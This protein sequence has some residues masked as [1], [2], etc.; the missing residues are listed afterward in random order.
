[1]QAPLRD[2]HLVRTPENVTFEFELAGVGSRGLAWV[3]DLAAMGALILVGSY[4]LAA[5]QPVLGGFAV[6][7]QVLA[8][9]LVIWW[10][11]ALC[12]W[13]LGGQTLG[14][15]AVGIRTLQT[16]GVRITFLQAVVRNLVRIVD[17]I[18]AFYLI[19]AAAALLDRR[20]RRLGDMAAGTVVVRERAAPM[21]SAVV[22][23]TER[24]NTF[25]RDPSII[26]A[27]RRITAPERDAMLALGLRRDALPLP[28][29]RRL[30]ARMA[31]HLSRRLDVRRPPHFSEEK[32]VLNLTA[33]LLTR[34]AGA[35]GQPKG[36]RT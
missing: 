23:S 20:G 6:A 27:A 1:M 5:A 29:R 28:L 30:F 7:A 14:K 9:S 26:Q 34:S 12:E 32:L 3:V 19:G 11:A 36:G 13:W 21:P 8:V 16:S 15:R 4:V 35:P 25:V 22:P 24:H 31:D 33:V 2:R 10:Y 18:P 17:L